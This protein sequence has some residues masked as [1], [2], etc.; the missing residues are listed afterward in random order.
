MS[1]AHAQPIPQSGD[2]P[3]RRLLD[4]LRQAIREQGLQQT[5]ISDIV[6]NARTSKRTFYECFTDKDACLVELADEWA[7]ALREA[8]D[9]GVDRQA[10]WDTQIDAA[11]DAFIA[12]VAADPVLSVA[13][14]R[15]LPA[16]G[17]RSLELWERDV[18]FYAAFYMELSRGMMMRRAGV[19]PLSEERAVILVGGL[20]ELIDRCLRTGQPL[21]AAGDAMKE[22]MKLM[23]GPRR[24][25]ADADAVSGAGVGP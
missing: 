21:D 4:G 3:R 5:T 2:G 9:V 16:L 24:R 6:R 15:E 8:V 14:S 13:I 1:A 11:V 17:G 23:I 10:Q 20:S 19:E 7:A 22:A 18:D 12:A 25:T